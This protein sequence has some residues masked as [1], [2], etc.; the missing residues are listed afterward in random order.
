MITV[1]TSDFVPPWIAAGLFPEADEVRLSQLATHWQSVGAQTSDDGT[2]VG[3]LSQRLTGTWE[4]T[5]ADQAIPRVRAVSTWASSISATTDSLAQGCGQASSY[6]EHVK[7]G[8]NT[9]LI[10]L[11]NSMKSAAMLASMC[12]VAIPAVA[13]Y[14]AQ[15]QVWAR[16]NLQQMNTALTQAMGDI[17]F[18][19]TI[20]PNL[21]SGAPQAPGKSGSAP[22]HPGPGASPLVR[23]APVTD[24][25]QVVGKGANETA[26]NAVDPKA[27]PQM[28][29]A[30]LPFA[31]TDQGTQEAGAAA[32][33]VLDQGADPSLNLTQFGTSAVANVTG[34]PSSVKLSDVISDNAMAQVAG[35]AP[36]SLPPGYP[37]TS[38]R[39]AVDDPVSVPPGSPGDSSSGS[40]HQVRTTYTTTTVSADTAAGGGPSGG[41]TVYQAFSAGMSAGGTT[42]SGAAQT[43]TTTTTTTPSTTWTQTTNGTAPTWVPA[44]TS[45]TGA[46]GVGTVD[47][48][49]AP[50]APAPTHPGLGAPTGGG[51][52]PPGLTAP[53]PTAGGQTSG[54]GGAIG[55][56]GGPAVTGIP[57]SPMVG[58]AAPSMP[59]APLLGA[60]T[61]PPTGV[62]APIGSSGQV[63]PPAAAA[64]VAAAPQAQQSGPGQTGSG[65]PGAGAPGSQQPG[66]LRLDPAKPG[67]SVSDAGPIYTV[68]GAISALGLA[69]GAAVHFARMWDDLNAG[70][71]TGA[72]GTVLPTQFGPDDS[73]LAS[74]PLGL[75]T[76]YQ[77]VLVPG[78]TDALFDGEVSTLRGLVYPLHA[79]RG[80]GRPAEL[81]DALG[82]GF[83]VHGPAGPDTL[84]FSRAADSVDVLRFAGVRTDDLVTPTD[85]GV[86]LAPDHV[87]V[88]LT[89]HHARPW[90][91][92]GEAPGSTSSH[93]IEEYEVLGYASVAIPHLAEIWRLHRD[94]TQ[95][96]VSTFNQRNGQWLF[97]LSPGRQLAGRRIENGAYATLRDSTVFR[98]VTLTDRHSVLIAYGVSAPE[99]FELVHDGTFRLSIENP[100]IRSLTGVTT[101]GTWQGMPV[102]LLHRHGLAILVDYAGDDS[103]Q[104]ASAGF[105]QLNQG[106]WVPRWV[107]HTEVSGVQELERPYSL[108]I[109]GPRKDPSEPPSP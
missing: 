81:F 25:A 63:P 35:A 44:P 32:K 80:Y 96:Y 22:G 9:T 87:P 78:E 89:R 102:H 73:Q 104:A 101:I 88:P 95:E 21:S 62:T 60:G 47:A 75:E 34:D 11:D 50:Q 5:S 90:I 67:M 93:V 105:V 10:S 97:D 6:T 71:V 29:P 61:L 17:T 51:S 26:Q 69:G 19:N 7:L 99:H 55:G 1:Y 72:R 46:A 41:G 13:A 28:P 79:V 84:A 59:T 16:A 4:G 100:Q 92:T 20:Q 30:L 39:P 45:G 18:E 52:Q 27:Q 106:Q 56:M 40:T 74:M 3:S 82:L 108:P 91:G 38:P 103:G 53:G 94:G 98:T 76:A 8:M 86:R 37:P 31:P 54:F 57:T 48:P 49:Y 77:K 107:D 64:P 43:P 83:A 85:E 12:P 109:P 65:Q 68:G 36:G 23:I 66:P 33:N 42:E 24:P 58:G 14:A 15:A 70:S 2:S